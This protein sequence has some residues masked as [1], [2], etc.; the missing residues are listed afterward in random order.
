MKGFRFSLQAILTL[1]QEAEQAAQR[2]YALR[3]TAVQAA[4]ARLAAL[5]QE[6][7]GVWARREKALAQGVQA[8]EVEALGS[9][10]AGLAEQRKTLVTEVQKARD[11]AHL[12][13]QQLLRASQERE[14]L[15]RYRKRRRLEFDQAQARAEQKM[16]DDLAGRAKPEV[17]AS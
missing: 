10:G 17:L 1:R 11:A 4:E 7:Q 6:V 8:H 16:L 3:L 14:T 2:Q 12:A 15:D 9:Y 13:W 5:D